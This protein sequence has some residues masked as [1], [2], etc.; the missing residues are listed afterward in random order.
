MRP[1]QA[2]PV[3]A[4][5]DPFNL[6]LL[7]GA[8]AIMLSGETA[9]GDFPAQAIALMNRVASLVENA[10]TL[11]D[12]A[13]STLDDEAIPSAVGGAIHELCRK[14]PVTKVI[15]L[16]ASGF[17]PKMISKYRL[18]QPILAVTNSIE[19]GRKVSLSWGVQPLVL[20]LKFSRR[21]SDHTFGR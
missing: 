13:G 5:D 16:T 19:V 15:C 3:D 6:R 21:S 12:E 7:D 9:I 1:L 14:L 17:A 8:S 10:E 20:E 4:S 18:K 2:F 11:P